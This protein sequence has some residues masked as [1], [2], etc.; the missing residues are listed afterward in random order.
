MTLFGEQ[1]NCSLVQYLLSDHALGMYILIFLLSGYGFSIFLWGWAKQKHAS[2]V[3]GYIT[4][5]FLGLF[6]QYGVEIM[7]RSFRLITQFD[8]IITEPH[9]W[10]FRIYIVTLSVLLIVGHMSYRIFIKKFKN[11]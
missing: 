5:L 3:Y 8:H 6:L 9:W 4:F 1:F 11:D 10:P 7:Q 2:H